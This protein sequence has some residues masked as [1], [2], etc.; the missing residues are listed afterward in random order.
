MNLRTKRDSIRSLNAANI[1]L[2]V[3]CAVVLAAC[4]GSDT[5]DTA[6]GPDAPAAPVADDVSASAE[7]TGPHL[8]GKITFDG[9]RPVRT[10]IQM[11]EDPK[12]TAMH[13]AE[14]L[15]SD[16][17][18]VGEDGAI[19]DVFVYIKEAPEGNYPV[20]P[21]QLVLDQIGCQYVPHVFGIQIGQELS[22]Q[23]SDPLLHNIRSFTRT[24]RPF[25]NAQPEGAPPRIKKFGKVELSIRMKCDLHPWMTA[26]IFALDHPFF[27]T[28]DESG[29]YAIHGLPP[30]DYTLVAWHEKYGEQETAITIAEDEGTAADF[31]FLPAE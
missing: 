14:P 20:P 1:L 22:V 30:G 27:A 21:E 25:N 3:I 6:A 7:D 23:N 28:T 19:K 2:A 31:V 29:A 11:A 4:G 5:K 9:P 16:R 15:L 18:I 10:V 12:C 24:N 8:S 13:A 17:E 26:F